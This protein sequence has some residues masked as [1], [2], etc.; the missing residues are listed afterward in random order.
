MHLAIHS[1]SYPRRK[2][3]AFIGDLLFDTGARKAVETLSPKDIAV[4][5]VAPVSGAV[6]WLDVS[7]RVV[8]DQLGISSNFLP[9]VLLLFGV[10]W[11]VFIIVAKDEPAPKAAGFVSTDETV[12]GPI[13]RNGPRVRLLGKLMFFLLLLLFPRA[14]LAW[15]DTTFPLPPKL[16]G[17]IEDEHS[18]QPIEGAR[19]RVVT[20]SGVDVTAGEWRSDS[21]GFYVVE[22]LRP[23]TRL[24]SLQV[25]RPDCPSGQRLSLQRNFQIPPSQAG[26][27]SVKPLFRHRLA[28]PPAP[29][30]AASP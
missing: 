15:L 24:A 14:V 23:V 21:R 11:C 22:T 27:A 30:N 9:P 16:Y 7:Q 3:V 17:Y 20:E 10:A 28:C 1:L 5:L 25:Y 12:S 29:L 6:A 19:V 4:A 2:V 13:Y 8:H 18:G 26:S